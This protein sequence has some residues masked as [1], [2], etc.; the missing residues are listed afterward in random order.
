MSPVT[1]QSQNNDDLRYGIDFS[2]LRATGTN[3]LPEYNLVEVVPNN[4][5]SSPAIYTDSWIVND[6][7]WTLFFGD[8]DRNARSGGN[9]TYICI[10]AYP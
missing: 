2:G 1:N 5:F 9:C 3:R 7:G 10:R 4:R 6:N 8:A